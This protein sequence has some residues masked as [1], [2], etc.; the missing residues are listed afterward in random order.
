[1]LQAKAERHAHYEIVLQFAQ[2]DD[3]GSPDYEVVQQHAA[4]YGEDHAHVEAA[5]PA[6]CLAAHVGRERRIHVDFGGGKFF[7][8]AGMAL[9]AG[10]R[11]IRSVRGGSRIARRKNAVRAMATGTVGDHLRSSPRRQPVIT[12]Q[13][14]GLAPALHSEFLRQTHAFMAARARGLTYVLS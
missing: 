3:L 4:D 10:A 6:N 12:G 9:S 13:I 5:N 2:R 14:R 11:E 7:C 1:V 8:D